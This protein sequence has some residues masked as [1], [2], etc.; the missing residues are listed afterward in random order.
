[1]SRTLNVS[2]LVQELSDFFVG[3]DLQPVPW[4]SLE[5]GQHVGAED[6]RTVVESSVQLTQVVVLASRGRRTGPFRVSGF[7]TFSV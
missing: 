3:L 4:P 5:G 1:M 6:F 2:H 7:I